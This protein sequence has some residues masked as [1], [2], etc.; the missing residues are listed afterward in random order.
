M[1]IDYDAVKRL[2]AGCRAGEYGTPVIAD[3]LETLLAE[4]LRMQ[5]VVEAAERWLFVQSEPARSYKD[6]DAADQALADSALAYRATKVT[7]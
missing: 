1:T 3:T 7:P 2:I 5:P 4:I 6:E